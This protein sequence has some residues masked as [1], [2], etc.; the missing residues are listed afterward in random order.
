VLVLVVYVWLLQPE[1]T[2]TLHGIQ[3]PGNDQHAQ[4]HRGHGGARHHGGHANRN[5]GGTGSANTGPPLL[6]QAPAQPAPPTAVGSEPPTTPS[7]D[8]YADEVGALQDGVGKV[9]LFGP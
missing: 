5:Q 4:H 8:Q 2:G 7:A 6:A 3:T 1:G 9:P